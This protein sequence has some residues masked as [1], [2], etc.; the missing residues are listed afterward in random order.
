M[1]VPVVKIYTNILP[2]IRDSVLGLQVRSSVVHRYDNWLLEEN[3][4][5]T[6]CNTKLKYIIIEKKIPTRNGAGMILLS[7]IA[8]CKVDPS[9]NLSGKISTKLGI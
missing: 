3:N 9:T 6:T 4:Y 1:P 8:L 5:Y 7:S 2:E